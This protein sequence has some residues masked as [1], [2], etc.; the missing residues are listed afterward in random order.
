MWVL[1]GE[2]TDT[3]GKCIGNVII[4]RLCFEPI[5]SFLLDNMQFEKC[6]H[7]TIAKLFNEYMNL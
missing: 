6:S 3:Y 7:K 2:S 5:K 4:G 1:I